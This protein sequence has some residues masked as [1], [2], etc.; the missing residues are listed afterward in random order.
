[1]A[2]WRLS[3]GSVWRWAN[4]SPASVSGVLQARRSARACAAEA[5]ARAG[6]GGEL[7]REIPERDRGGDRRIRQYRLCPRGAGANALGLPPGNE[8][9]LFA[10]GRVPSDG[11]RMR[12]SNWRPWRPDPPPRRA[13]SEL[14]RGAARLS[15]G[16][17]VLTAE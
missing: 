8:L 7:T 1:M 10:M 15:T 2:M 9:V 3:S 6:A 14:H 17:K 16:R 4:V 12:A 13:I 5:L 11:S